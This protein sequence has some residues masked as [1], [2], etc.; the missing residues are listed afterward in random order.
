MKQ[1][2]QRICPYV[3]HALVTLFYVAIPIF[4][5][6]FMLAFCDNFTANDIKQIEIEWSVLYL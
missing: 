3:L 2:A 4:L 5:G 6:M 1:S